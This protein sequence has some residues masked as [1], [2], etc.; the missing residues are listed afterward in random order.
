MQNVKGLIAKLLNR[1]E[2]DIEVQQRIDPSI[3]A[4][5]IIQIGDKTIDMS[6]IAKVNK[7]RNELN[8]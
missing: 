8:G 4:G 5:L 7:F 3:I 6:S 2:S 1:S